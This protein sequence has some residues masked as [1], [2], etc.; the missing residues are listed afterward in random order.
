MSMLPLLD[1]EQAF[2]ATSGPPYG[3][4]NGEL[5]EGLQLR[6]KFAAI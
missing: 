2:P 4:P 3:D 5:I 6:G 1:R